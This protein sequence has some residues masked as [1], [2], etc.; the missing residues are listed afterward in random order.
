VLKV[1]EEISCTQ[2][3]GTRWI[4]VA[5]LLWGSWCYKCLLFDVGVDLTGVSQ[6]LAC[7]W[8]SSSKLLLS[9]GLWQH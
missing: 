4:I 5:S 6:L 2:S 8:G 1:P 7:S 9:L 3:V